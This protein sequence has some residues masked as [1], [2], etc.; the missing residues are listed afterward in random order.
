M[1]GK[2]I[3]PTSFDETIATENATSEFLSYYGCGF[4]ENS[5]DSITLPYR[6]VIQD[7]TYKEDYFEDYVLQNG[8]D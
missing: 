4:A 7:F 3:F 6:H 2:I 5:K 1:S 8:A